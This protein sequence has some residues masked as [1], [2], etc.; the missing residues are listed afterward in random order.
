MSFQLAARIKFQISLRGPNEKKKKVEYSWFIRAT[1]HTHCRGPIH[2][3][4][5]ICKPRSTDLRVYSANSVCT[6]AVECAIYLCLKP[7]IIIRLTT[8]AAPA[9]LSRADSMRLFCSSILRTRFDEQHALFSWYLCKFCTI[10]FEIKFAKR[11]CSNMS[12]SLKA[13]GG[14]ITRARHRCESV[15]FGRGLLTRRFMYAVNKPARCKHSPALRRTYKLYVKVYLVF[16]IRLYE[17]WRFER[18]LN[19]N[20]NLIIEIIEIR[21]IYF[22]YYYNNTFSVNYNKT[23]RC[24]WYTYYVVLTFSNYS[25]RSLILFLQYSIHLFIYLFY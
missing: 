15:R 1:R 17:L 10:L 8:D 5:V 3:H 18:C 22:Y 9:P 20:L 4:A 25:L 23:I 13:S 6:A 16:T 24:C 21:I 14:G 7:H 19:N 2:V 12:N 11:K